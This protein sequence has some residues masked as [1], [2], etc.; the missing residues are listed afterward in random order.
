MDR[1]LHIEVSGFRISVSR[2]YPTPLQQRSSPSRT[3]WCLW[4]G[5]SQGLSEPM[6][7]APASS[8]VR[9]ALGRQKL[10]QELSSFP[11][12]FSHRIR[13]NAAP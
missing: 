11:E 7:D 4:W 1:E 6:L 2:A 5:S 10:Q 8:S 12:P 3:L 9:G 13:Q